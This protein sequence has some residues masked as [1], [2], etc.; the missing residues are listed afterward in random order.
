M[1][2][3]EINSFEANLGGDFMSFPEKLMS[4]MEKF[5]MFFWILRE[6]F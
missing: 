1:S 3:L 6:Y 2:L 5:W 4:G